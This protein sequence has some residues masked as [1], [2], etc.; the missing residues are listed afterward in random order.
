MDKQCS[1]VASFENIYASFNFKDQNATL[2]IVSTTGAKTEKID[3]VIKNPYEQSKRVLSSPAV[4]LYA[5]R[6]LP[7]AVDGINVMSCQ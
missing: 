7:M 3:Q 1:Q 6:S 4:T 2:L 5:S